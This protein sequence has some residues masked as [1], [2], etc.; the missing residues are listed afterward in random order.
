MMKNFEFRVSFANDHGTTI[1]SL[2][3]TVPHYV[4]S[5]SSDVASD[6]DIVV[7]CYRLCPKSTVR[8][9]VGLGVVL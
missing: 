9:R 3:L 7:N 5:E 2:H 8:W 4:V 6:H 1:Q